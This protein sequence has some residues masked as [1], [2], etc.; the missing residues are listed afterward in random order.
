MDPLAP[1]RTAHRG[2]V[3]IV[4]VLVVAGLSPRIATALIPT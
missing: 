1:R 3:S 4:M 2:I